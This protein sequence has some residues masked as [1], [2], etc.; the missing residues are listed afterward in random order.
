[1][2]VPFSAQVVSGSR[3]F[4]LEVLND[5]TPVKRYKFTHQKMGWMGGGREGVGC[6]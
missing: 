1:M 5:F 2:H 4:F 3:K 6:G